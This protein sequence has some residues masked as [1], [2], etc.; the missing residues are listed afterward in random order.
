MLI[1]DPD[2]NEIGTLALSDGNL[3]LL[4]RDAELSIHF[5]TPR[6]LLFKLGAHNFTF[7]L[8]QHGDRVSAQDIEAV[9]KYIQLQHDIREAM[10]EHDAGAEG[11]C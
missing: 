9:R 5:H 1:F 3:A 8:R 2:G 4:E 10:E 11:S 6:M 7:S